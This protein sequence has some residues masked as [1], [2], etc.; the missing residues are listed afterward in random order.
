MAKKRKYDENKRQDISRFEYVSYGRCWVCGKPL[1]EGH[2]LCEDCYKR[3]FAV[4]EIMHNHPNTLKA[5]EKMK[6]ERGL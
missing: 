6:K 3:Q 1:Y 4:A 5:R 2:K